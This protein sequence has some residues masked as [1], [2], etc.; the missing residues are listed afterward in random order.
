ME[1]RPSKYV[2]MFTIHLHLK[3]KSRS[4]VF[5]LDPTPAEVLLAPDSRSPL[6]KPPAPTKPETD[7]SLVLESKTIKDARRAAVLGVRKA[8]ALATCRLRGWATP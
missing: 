4:F 5:N 8:A 1:C 7:F 6:A 2:R 3:L